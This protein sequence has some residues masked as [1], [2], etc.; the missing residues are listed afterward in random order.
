MQKAQTWSSI[1]SN[2]DSGE[3]KTNTT[4]VSPLAQEVYNKVKNYTDANKVH[5]AF[6]LANKSPHLTHSASELLNAGKTEK[7]TDPKLAA[8][9]LSSK[10]NNPFTPAIP[11]KKI[12]AGKAVKS[13][14]IKAKPVKEEDPVKA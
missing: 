3:T 9:L 12:P 1:K 4:L 7:S 14:I 5:S 2:I 10:S 8:E 6:E 13:D 11:K